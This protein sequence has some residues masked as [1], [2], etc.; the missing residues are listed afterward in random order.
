MFSQSCDLL[1]KSCSLVAQI[2]A[3]QDDGISLIKRFFGLNKG[4]QT[5]NFYQFLPI[6]YMKIIFAN[7][8]SKKNHGFLEAFGCG[9]LYLPNLDF[10][11]Y[12]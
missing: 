8:K 6:I 2:Y 10:A 3:P 12:Q 4:K 7:E 5:G 11:L 9:R 1:K